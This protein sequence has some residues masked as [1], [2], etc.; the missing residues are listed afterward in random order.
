METTGQKKRKNKQHDHT[1]LLMS[2]N[3]HFSRSILKFLINSDYNF[4]YKLLIIYN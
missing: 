4:I 1:V 3:P 2:P